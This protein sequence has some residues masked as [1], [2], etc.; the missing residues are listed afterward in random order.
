MNDSDPILKQDQSGG[1]FRRDDILVP[2]ADIEHSANLT[3]LFQNFDLARDAENIARHVV[4]Q[5]PLKTVTDKR[6]DKRPRCIEDLFKRLCRMCAPNWQMKKIRN[7]EKFGAD[8]ERWITRRELEHIGCK[9]AWGGK[10][11]ENQVDAAL[12]AL[13]FWTIIERRKVYDPVKRTSKI[14]IRIC[15][16]NILAMLSAKKECALVGMGKKIRK[17]A[18]PV[19]AADLIFLTP[20]K[21]WPQA[22]AT[23]EQIRAAAAELYYEPAL[24]KFLIPLS[25]CVKGHPR[26]VPNRADRRVIVEDSSLVE[27]LKLLLNKWVVNPENLEFRNRGLA[28]TPDGWRALS[29]DE[30]KVAGYTDAQIVRCKKLLVASGFLEWKNLPS[31]GKHEPRIYA[32]LRVDLMLEWMREFNRT[33]WFSPLPKRADDGW[34]PSVIDPRSN[35]ILN[36]ASVNSE[37]EPVSAQIE[38]KVYPAAAGHDFFI[39]IGEQDYPLSSAALSGYSADYRAAVLK[40]PLDSGDNSFRS[41]TR[42]FADIFAEYFDDPEHPFDHKIAARLR[43]LV[44]RGAIAHKLTLS[45]LIKWKKQR[46]NF[47]A[48]NTDDDWKIFQEPK[49]SD[50]MVKMLS[51]WTGI[52]RELNQPHCSMLSEG[53]LESITK[54]ANDDDMS[55][56]EPYIRGLKKSIQDD[57]QRGFFDFPLREDHKLPTLVALHE[58]G[59]RRQLAEYIRDDRDE[60]IRVTKKYWDFALTLRKCYPDLMQAL[61]LPPQHWEELLQLRRQNF[62][63][64]QVQLAQQ[65]LYNNRIDDLNAAW[66]VDPDAG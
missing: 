40:P 16:E 41:I 8:G 5:D 46:D 9:R 57:L 27:F 11:S 13:E 25:A 26:R 47:S 63:L 48:G 6:R 54:H 19:I 62:Q 66:L 4:G 37:I 24:K 2:D 23:G 50:D 38:K 29:H 49:T 42:L 43:A 18:A 45:D 7:P 56:W 28:F 53:S 30:L 52:K 64:A 55:D 35:V 61:N 21:F 1:S 3:R 36:S 51:N 14:F 15:P 10:Y 31:P 32:R 17:R 34:I 65:R 58:L 39:K 33:G 20:G 60:L 44:H 22:M 12:A 59:L